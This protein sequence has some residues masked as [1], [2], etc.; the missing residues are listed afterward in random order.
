MYQIS[1]T[2][3][4]NSHWY[5]YEQ[6]ILPDDFFTYQN[7]LSQLTLAIALLHAYALFDILPIILQAEEFQDTKGVI[8]IRIWKKDRQHSGQKKKYKR[9]NND[10]QNIHIK[11]NIE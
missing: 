6:H 3:G 1:A 10:L 4:S 11:L 9:R 8:R 2:S 5:S 7:L